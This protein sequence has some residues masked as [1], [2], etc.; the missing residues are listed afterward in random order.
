VADTIDVTDAQYFI[1]EVWASD[2]LMFRERALVMAPLV[3]RYDNEVKQKGDYVHIPN[4]S[5]LTA[6][7]KDANS[8]VTLNVPTETE[9]TIS[10]NVHKECSFE[11]LKTISTFKLTSG[12][13]RMKGIH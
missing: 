5:E 4:V 9:S 2:V 6:N 3:A 10:I 7:D 11:S 12:V 1:P 8:E 13:Q